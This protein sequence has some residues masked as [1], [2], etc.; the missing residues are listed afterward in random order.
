MFFEPIVGEVR[1]P[2]ELCHISSQ[3]QDPRDQGNP[4]DLGNPGESSETFRFSIPSIIFATF[5]GK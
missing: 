3:L 5:V 4:W 2:E 1:V